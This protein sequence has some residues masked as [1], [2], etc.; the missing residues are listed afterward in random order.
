MWLVRRLVR[1]QLDYLLPSKAPLL[2]TEMEG[3]LRGRKKL[4]SLLPP[5]R[6]VEFNYA[7][8]NTVR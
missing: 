5:T 8:E 3:I 7:Q 4:T 1:F 6:Y 2:M